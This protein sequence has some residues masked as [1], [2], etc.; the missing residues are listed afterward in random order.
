M[1]QKEF[2]LIEEML[3]INMEYYDLNTDLS[4]VSEWDSFNILFFMTKIEEKYGSKLTL[5]DISDLCQVKDLVR[6]LQQCSEK[7]EG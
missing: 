7:Y 1:Y 5:E 3:N 6:L 4:E 2:N